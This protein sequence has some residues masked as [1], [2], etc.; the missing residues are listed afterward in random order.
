MKLLDRYIGREMLFTTLFGV[1]VMTFVLVL[2]N[3]FKQLLDVMINQAVPLDLILSFVAY[4]IPFSLTYTIPWGFVTA[5]LLVFGKLSGENELVA[6]R[7][8]GISTTRI[9]VPLFALALVCVAICLWINL[10]VA[11]R[12]QDNAKNAMV[13]VATQDPLSLFE[14]DHIIDEFPDKK[15]YVEDK[16]GA[17][18]DNIL[19][20]ELDPKD[21]SVQRVLYAKRGELRTSDDAVKLHI[22]NAQV[23]QHDPDAPGDLKKIQEG[24]TMQESVFSIPLDKLIARYRG[25]RVPSRKSLPELWNDVADYKAHPGTENDK[26]LASTLTEI[27]K[28]FSFS[29]ASFALA[30]I[31]V[32][33]AITAHRKETS[34][35]F[36]FSIIV[37]FGYFFF[38]QLGTMAQN[39]P[40]L[41]PELLIWLPDIVFILFGS[42]LFWRL[43]RQ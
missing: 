19:V 33:L 9:C 11:P 6:M 15:I 42:A 25:L 24:I 21:A 31:A 29:L 4:I 41:H 10:D 22:F 18:L 28:R 40:K 8:S 35:G 27:N 26:R 12:A 39:N 2:G 16:H 23:E 13:R 32:P 36:L 43:S 1:S 3:L 20:Y 7:S 14:S 30:L 17:E 5:V 37:A 38:I 34:I